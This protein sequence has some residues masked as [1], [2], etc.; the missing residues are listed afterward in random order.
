MSRLLT[1]TQMRWSTFEKEGYAIYAAVMKFYHVLG[2]KY[3]I[4]VTDHKNLTYIRDSGSPKVMNWKHE[5]MAF[6]FGLYYG[7]GSTNVVADAFSRLLN[8]DEDVLRAAKGLAPRVSE[9]LNS[10]WE[11]VDYG[12]KWNYSGSWSSLPSM[13]QL[14]EHF[15]SL[16]EQPVELLANI[17]QRLPLPLNV[18]EWFAQV[19]NSKVGH[20][21]SEVTRLRLSAQG[22]VWSGMRADIRQGISECPCCQKMSQIQPAIHVS[23]KTLATGAPMVMISMDTIGPLD[24]DENGNQY[25]LVIIDHFTRWVELYATRTTTAEEATPLLVSYFGR[26]GFAETVSTDGGAQFCNDLVQSLFRAV[27]G[28]HIKC[29]PHSKEEM[30]IVE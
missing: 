1:P 22:H 3:F 25:V 26:Y 9:Q 14:P 2:D 15:A 13:N 17:T 23:P 5:L 11:S 6:D 12:N 24:A 10:I 28:F 20:A 27:G 30:G 18:R 8:V 4:I 16:R 7:P 21:G 29:T 19:H